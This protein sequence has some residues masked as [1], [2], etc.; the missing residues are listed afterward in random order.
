VGGGAGGLARAVG[1]GGGT[2]GLTRAAGTG[3]SA[4]DSG[5]GGSGRCSAGGWQSWWRQAQGA[6]LVAAGGIGSRADVYP[7]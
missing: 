4:G 7:L 2:G 5:Y 1:M 3:G 6:V